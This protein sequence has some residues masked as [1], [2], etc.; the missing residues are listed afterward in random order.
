MGVIPL[1][2]QTSGRMEHRVKAKASTAAQ[3]STM[4][5]S[6]AHAKPQELGSAVAEAVVITA[7]GEIERFVQGGGFRQEAQSMYKVQ[8]NVTITVLSTDLNQ[9]NKLSHQPT[10]LKELKDLLK[11]N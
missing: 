5:S 4:R 3:E 1:V 7:I 9:I 10:P 11:W 8:L 2:A 6:F